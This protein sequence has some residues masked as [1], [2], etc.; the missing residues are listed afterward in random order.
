MANSLLKAAQQMAV[1][2]AAAQA[3]S[4]RI[5]TAGGNRRRG[6]KD[7]REREYRYGCAQRHT[8]QAAAD[9]ALQAHA[10][11]E[12]AGLLIG[13]LAPAHAQPEGQPQIA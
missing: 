6:G 2:L 10:A 3:A 4:R 11:V 5:C 8:A 13:D 7:G 12:N 9:A 1:R